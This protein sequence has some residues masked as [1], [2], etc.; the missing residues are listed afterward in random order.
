[1]YC[2]CSPIQPHPLLISHAYHKV[3]HGTLQLVN[4]SLIPVL[5][6]LILIVIVSDPV[7]VCVCVFVCVCL[8]VVCVCVCVCMCVCVCVR[9]CM[10]VYVCVYV[11]MHVRTRRHICVHVPVCAHA[12]MY[13]HVYMHVCKKYPVAVYCKYTSFSSYLCITAGDHVISFTGTAN[14]SSCAETVKNKLLYNFPRLTI[15][16]S[17]NLTTVFV[18]DCVYCNS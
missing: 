8:C 7:C 5:T 17:Y 13:V 4:C 18:S 9:V 1:M 11:S 3:T 14:S 10:C 16:S 2:C 6:G 12:C 15:N